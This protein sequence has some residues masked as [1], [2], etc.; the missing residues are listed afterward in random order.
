MTDA[1]IEC[2]IGNTTIY[3]RDFMKSLILYPPTKHTI[4]LED[5]IW[6]NFEPENDISQ[7]ILTIEKSVVLKNKMKDDIIN[8]V[9]NNPPSIPQHV[10]Q[11]IGE[12]I[13]NDDYED[14]VLEV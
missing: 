7:P 4:T 8:T 5:S 11:L 1:Y 10:H 3:H 13:E 14:H 9:S 12:A 2:I 6:D